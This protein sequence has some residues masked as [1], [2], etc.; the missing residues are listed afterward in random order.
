MDSEAKQLLTSGCLSG[1][2]V[3]PKVPKR[4]RLPESKYIRTCMACFAFLPLKN[5]YPKEASAEYSNTHEEKPTGE[6][7]N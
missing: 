1:V 3:E 6:N 4:H 5:A 7:R 2:R